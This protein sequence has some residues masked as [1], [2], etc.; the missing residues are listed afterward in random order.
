MAGG[1]KGSEDDSTLRCSLCGRRSELVELPG[2]TEKYC[3]ECSA[4]IATSILLT[5]EIAVAMSEREIE[6]LVAELTQVS[7]Q[8]LERAQSTDC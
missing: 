5:S 3:S 2:R 8:M 7:K 4:D 6:G 1:P